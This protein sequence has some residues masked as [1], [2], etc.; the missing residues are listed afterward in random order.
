V[1]DLRKSK[2]TLKRGN[3]P[4]PTTIAQIHEQAKKASEEKEKETMK[5][6]GSSRGGNTSQPMSRQGS[7]RG[8]GRDIQ[9]QSSSRSSTQDRNQNSG[10]SSPAASS[11]GWN[12]VGTGSPTSAPRP[13]R[14]DLAN[15][16]KTDRKSKSGILGPSSSPF[17][18]LARSGSKTGI[19]KKA[20]PAEN[21][22]SSPATSMSNMFS[23]L[24]GEGHEEE[25]TGERKK[26]QL[27]PR[28][29]A[30][31]P[32]SDEAEKT[33]DASATSEEK[34]KLSDE[35]IERRS[36]STI[37]EYFSLRDKKVQSRIVCFII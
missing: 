16:G 17:S 7:H 28:G 3:Q 9:R 15:F 25:S 27:L 1:F 26:L 10:S 33:E 34:P 35:V 19:D 23:A 2:W 37:E 21:R 30:D 11:D 12:T 29:T 5:R 13:G 24:G 31:S 36:K 14:N 22:S 32:A 4:A 6:S 20:S 8:G 18:S